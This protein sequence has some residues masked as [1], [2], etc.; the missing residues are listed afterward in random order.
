[1]DHQAKLFVYQQ[2]RCPTPESSL[3]ATSVSF[4]N[5]PVS[6][7]GFGYLIYKDVFAAREAHWGRALLKTLNG[8]STSDAACYEACT[9]GKA[10]PW[11][12]SPLASL[13]TLAYVFW[14]MEHPNLKQQRR[15]RP[16]SLPAHL[17]SYG[18]TIINGMAF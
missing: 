13:Q 18:W 17:R 16:N 9:T 15:C 1:M 3:N 8:A 12:L 4:I 5:Q 10:L 2:A 7:E 14:I 11:H 6:P